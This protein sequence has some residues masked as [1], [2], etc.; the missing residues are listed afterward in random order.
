MLNNNI[1][2]LEDYSGKILVLM[3]HLKLLNTIVIS[4]KSKNIK[5]L[6]YNKTITITAR[7]A[8][9][10]AFNKDKGYKVLLIILASSG[11]RILLMG[12]SNLI[13]LKPS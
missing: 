1:G 11:E 8:I 10:T 4:L 12:V 5:Y 6:K 13:I 9:E 7:G 3:D 2:Q